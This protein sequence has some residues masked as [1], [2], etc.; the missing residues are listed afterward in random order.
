MDELDTFVSSSS[1]SSGSSSTSN[2]KNAAYITK[3]DKDNTTGTNNNNSSFV[4]HQERQLLLYHLLERV[5]RAGSC[6]NFIGI[7]SDSTIMMKLE[8]RIKSRAEGVSK[9]IMT[10]SNDHNTF[11]NYIVPILCHSI[12]HEN[13]DRENNDEKLFSSSMTSDYT[14][15]NLSKGTSLQQEVSNVFMLNNDNSCT[16]SEND[17]PPQRQRQGASFRIYE[18][19]QRH[20]NLGKDVRWFSNIL[21]LALSL[22]RYDVILWKDQQQQ[23]NFSPESG[24]LFPKFHYKYI[25]EA[26]FDMGGSLVVGWDTN[27][28]TTSSAGQQQH[29]KILPESADIRLQTLHDLSG[30]LLALV[31]SAR[32]ILYRDSCVQ[33]RISNGSNQNNEASM[34]T[35][36]EYNPQ[37]LTLRRMINEYQTS[38]KGLTSKYSLRILQ[39]SFIELLEI[40][41]FRPSIDHSGT[42]PF[43]YQFRDAFLY[44]HHNFDIIERLPLHM[45]LDI[46]YDIKHAIDNNLLLNCSTALRE[47][48]RKIN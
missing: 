10:P 34:S 18:T 39:K 26:I 35:A 45:T 33:H 21:Y 24:S 42:I 23:Y 27:A 14:L 8:K 16:S 5:T 37:Q 31:L 20:Y 13:N 17:Q 25:E 46:H 36:A 19:L 3:R 4:F 22:Y 28:S 48:G 43:Q 1:N 15:T 40:G 30:P 9:F 6:C 38:Y 11:D 29:Q 47:W 41:I 44:Q 2:N 32:R 7:S 12:A